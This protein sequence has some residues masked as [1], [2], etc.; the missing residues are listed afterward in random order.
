MSP[1]KHDELMAFSLAYTHLIGRIGERMNI[2]NTAIDTKGFTQLLKVQEYVVN[3]SA[4]IFKDMHNFNLYA[5][6]MREQF[7]QALT[8]I[9][10]ELA[11][12]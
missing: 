3:D 1:E 12:G 11:S 8:E 6:K 7:R 2:N 9:E 5:R 10:E 4:R